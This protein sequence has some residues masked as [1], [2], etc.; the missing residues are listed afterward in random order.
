MRHRMPKKSLAASGWEKTVR[1]PGQRPATAQ[2]TIAAARRVLDIF[3]AVRGAVTGL[4]VLSGGPDAPIL[5][6]K[7]VEEI[8]S[9]FPFDPNAL[10]ALGFFQHE[11]HERVA[12]WL[13]A[14]ASKGMPELLT[15]SITELG[16]HVLTAIALVPLGFA[17]FGWR[18]V[19][20][21]NEFE[22]GLRCSGFDNTGFV[23]SPARNQDRVN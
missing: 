21:H 20:R 16:L 22:T 7:Q 1:A 14:L 13:R 6:S 8:L 18:P 9:E 5:S 2:V 12:H 11:F 3:M 10:V 23:S 19:E 15:C 4:P 17:T